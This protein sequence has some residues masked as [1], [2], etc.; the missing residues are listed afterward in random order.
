MSLVATTV[1]E[2]VAITPISKD[3]FISD[4]N[5]G[6]MG[7]MAAIGYG[8]CTIAI[9]VSAACQ[10]VD[11][12]YH[13]YSCNGNYLGPAQ[14]DRKFLC[15]VTRIRDTRTFATRFVEVSQEQADGSRRPCMT[16]LADFQVAETDS[17]MEYSAPPTIK[18]SDVDACISR[19]ETVER[20]VVAGKVSRKMQKIYEK[21]F[22]FLRTM[23]DIRPVLD[24]V[25]GQ[26]LYGMAKTLETT[27]DHLSLTEKTT[28]EWIR[29]KVPVTTQAEHL[30]GL[31]LHIDA[32]ISFVPL[33]HSHQFLDD[34][35]ACSSLDF[36]IRVFSNEVDLNAWNVKEWKTVHGSNGRTYTE[37][38]IW[39]RRGIL[40]ANMTQMNIMR[41]KAQKSKAAL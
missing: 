38:R 17:V 2:Q 26:N 10:T 41:P 11:D 39:D 36:A 6:W 13:L 18:S 7:N 9:G 5:P 12:K 40:V 19:D 31:V 14:T 8:G 35:G 32:G 24:S 30:A 28:G 15:K 37:C 16:M 25:G 23:Y 3:D 34:V 27:Q 21:V 22:G 1:A 20:L 33:I 4:F 29:A